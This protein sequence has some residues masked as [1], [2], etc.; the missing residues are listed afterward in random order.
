MSAKDDDDRYSAEETARRA[1]EVI[2]RMLKTPPQPRRSANPK[3]PSAPRPSI[4][5]GKPRQ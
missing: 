1:D 2:K 5:K 3:K 4:R